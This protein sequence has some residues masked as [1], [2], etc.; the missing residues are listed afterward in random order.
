MRDGEDLHLGQ[1]LLRVVHTPGHST[2]VDLLMVTNPPRSPM[3]SLLLSGDTL[4]VGDVGRPDFGGPD[5][6]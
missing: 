3:P 4:F 2:R 6:A 1:L 5:G